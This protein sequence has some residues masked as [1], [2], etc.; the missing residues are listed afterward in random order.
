MLT[1]IFSYPNSFFLTKNSLTFY[2]RFY[3]YKVLFFLFTFSLYFFSLLFLFT[4]SLYFFSFSFL[5]LTLIH[6]T[7]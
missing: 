6:L 1:L 7:G 2:L 5:V 3:I 4:F